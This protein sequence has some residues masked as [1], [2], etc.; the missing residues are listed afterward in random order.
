MS[1]YQ[2][3]NSTGEFNYKL[4]Y[5]HHS[6]GWQMNSISVLRSDNEVFSKKNL[7]G[8]YR[9]EAVLLAQGISMCEAVIARLSSSAAH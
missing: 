5:S 1:T 9:A 3:A 4:K 6:D 7:A 2:T 8:V